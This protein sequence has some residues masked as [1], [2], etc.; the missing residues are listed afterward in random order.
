M[1]IKNHFKAF[2][3]CTCNDDWD[4]IKIEFC[5][6][7]HPYNVKKRSDANKITQEHRRKLEKLKSEAINVF[8]MKKREMKNVRKTK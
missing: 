4:I 8:V 1:N 6:F 7:C 5:E 2:I 3:G